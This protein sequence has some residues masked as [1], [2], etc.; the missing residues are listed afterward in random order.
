M[1]CFRIKSMSSNSNVFEEHK[2]GSDT[3]SVW[4]YYLV[5][6][7]GQVAKCKQCSKEIK[8]CGGSTSGLHTHLKTIH[9]V[10]LKTK[11]DTA[12]NTE[13][14]ASSSSQSQPK[15]ITLCDYF[16][17]KKTE[18]LC[19]ILARM[20]AR[21]GLPFRIFSSSEDIRKGLVARGYQDIPKSAAIIKSMTIEYSKS[22][23]NKIINEIS[24][25]KSKGK[26]FSLT[27]D[28]WTSVRNRRYL[29]I[30]VHSSRG[31]IWNIGLARL[32]GR[33]P[34]EKCLE[35]LEIKLQ[36]H[37][38]NL[39]KD[40]VCISTDGASV[41][42]KL[43]K[44]IDVAHQLCFA[45]GIHLAVIDVLYKKKLNLAIVDADTEGVGDAE[46]NDAQSEDS[47][48]DTDDGN[49]NDNN[50]EKEK[51]EDYG[52]TVE[53]SFI[54][55]EINLN[56]VYLSPLVTKIRKV[57]KIFRRSPTK[58]DQ[59][60]QKYVKLEFGKEINL[61]LDVI[62]RW[63][64][65]LNMLERFYE[66]RHCVQKALID[67]NSNLN[68]CEA[69]F[70]L[71]SATV[72]ALTPIKLGVEALC[73]QDSNLLVA[74]ATI[75]F[76]I[77]TLAAQKSEISTD[78]ANALKFRISQRRTDLS[79]VLQYLHRA[80]QNE[81]KNESVDTDLFP[82]IS[83][84]SITKS[85]V[86]LVKRLGVG[87]ETNDPDPDST[88]EDSDPEDD[89][90]LAL[91]LSSSS[92]AINKIDLLKN[93]LQNVINKTMTSIPNPSRGKCQGL[94][95]Q[96]KKEM[97]FFEEEGIKGVHLQSAYDYL[98]TIAPTSVE[99][100]RAFSAALLICTKL[101][102]RLSDETLDHICFLKSYFNTKK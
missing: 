71:I 91:S 76:M 11:S 49:N 43:G 87:I 84:A 12:V 62:T 65:L 98:T 9:K 99:S 23:R 59:Y 64:S 89:I 1:N 54:E 39:S 67:L 36:E 90:P 14:D 27:F 32:H 88:A 57:I 4:H 79:Q 35:V 21:D 42:V 100:E 82:R 53:F 69:D 8:C 45:H 16:K 7:Q 80:S 5:D 102:S 81:N 66:L 34:A 47:D 38:L 40:I 86:R 41:M 6:K 10:N 95:Q 28:E 94:E 75:K 17:S 92:V 44:L 51:N 15:K 37:G 25:L 33:V 50:E 24:T 30:N 22:V 70:T 73:R 18:Q 83:K 78:L 77:E 2:K 97:S 56:Y 60:L 93:K 19:E 63:N 52:D 55:T 96:V 31:L 74:D 58:N 20:V 13:K 85:I 46:A 3:F 68:F 26:R 101:R 72:A 61:Q 48:S 29:N